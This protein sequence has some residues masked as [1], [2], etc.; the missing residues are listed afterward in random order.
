LVR[1]NHVTNT[2][3]LEQPVMNVTTPAVGAD[4]LARG[5]MRFTQLMKA[6]A[7]DSRLGR[8]GGLRI[9]RAAF[10]T[11]AICH[12]YLWTGMVSFFDLTAALPN[13]VGRLNLAR[14]Q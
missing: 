12:L 10:R 13:Y 11:T 3:Y 1:R 14:S 9:A 8:R 6:S 7:C 4:G 2:G 5:S